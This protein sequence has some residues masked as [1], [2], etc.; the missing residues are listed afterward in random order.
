MDDE[1]AGRDCIRIAAAKESSIEIIGECVDGED[2][3]TVIRDRDPDLVFLDVQMP[4]LDGFGVI[5][6]VGVDHMPAVVFVTAFDRHA[7]R[8]FEVHAV[9]FVLKPFDD[10]RL[11]DAVGRVRRRLEA[12]EDRELRERL[13][14]IL[15]M[16]RSA[17][18]KDSAESYATRFAVRT[19]ERTVFVPTEEVD[20][21][22]AAG[23]HIKIHVGSEV[24][25]MRA[26][27]AGTAAKLDPNT[28]AR[29]H[30]STVVNVTRIKEVQP[31]WGG[32]YIAVLKDGRQLKVSRTFRDDLLRP[33]A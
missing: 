10:Q 14:G 22:E 31:W 7:L 27:L 23:N 29:I 6:Q 15:D 26:T 5:E 16:Y 8:A 1:P 25:T 13:S 19:G 2:A 28:F 3:V 17:R 18:P 33:I 9:D 12:G 21:I 24:H 20:F 11:L 4:G 32:D 30:R